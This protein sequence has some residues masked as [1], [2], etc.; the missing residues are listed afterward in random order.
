[1]RKLFVYLFLIGSIL[2]IL[3]YCLQ[4]YSLNYADFLTT[5]FNIV[6]YNNILLKFN[7]LKQDLN[8]YKNENEKLKIE[9][10]KLKDDNDKLSNE[11]KKANKIILNNTPKEYNHINEINTLKNDILLKDNQILK[12]QIQLQSAVSNTKTVNYDDIMVVY[13]ISSDQKLNHAVKCLK[14]DTFA[15]VEEK[16][17][18]KYEQYRETNNNFVA[19][20]TI[21][22]RFKKMYENKIKDGDKIQLLDV[23]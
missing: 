1:M 14:T 3:F 18:Q 9:N 8:K 21:I 17:Y 6:D 10:N 4:Y 11:L 15:E 5:E 22:L 19:R 7:K 20:G 23:I 12:L 16:L 2:L 13:F